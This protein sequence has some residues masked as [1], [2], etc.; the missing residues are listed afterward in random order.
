MLSPVAADHVQRP[1]NQG[2]LENATHYGVSGSPGEGPYVE[3]WLDIRDGKIQ[4]A[5]YR[6]PGCPS[7][8]AAASM[9]CQLALGKSFEWIPSLTGQD[10]LTILG[11]LPEGKEH[12]AQRAAEALGNAKLLEAKA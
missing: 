7:S 2:P 8:T 1:R 3:I 12:Y 4:R 11:G 9:T 6:T 10:V 5:G